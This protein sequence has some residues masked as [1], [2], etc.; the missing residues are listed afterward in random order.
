MKLCFN[1]AEKVSKGIDALKEEL[2]IEIVS[3]KSAEVVV[4]VGE[5]TENVVI[6][7]LKGTTAFIVYGGGKSRFFR[8]LATLV[9]WISD[10]VTE[11]R[12]EQHPLFLRNGAMGDMSG[13]MMNIPTLKQML[14]KMALMGLSTYMPYTEDTYEIE[15]RPYFGHMMGRY[16]KAELRE[17][18]EYANMLGI[19]LIPC[20]QVLGHM[21]SHLRWEAAAPYKDTESVL[22]ADADATY[23]LIDDM[24]RTV[25]ECF[26]TKRVHIGMDETK[27][28]GSGNFLEKN[29]FEPRQD[30]YFRHLERVKEIAAKYGLEPMMWSDMFFRL[31]GSKLDSYS[32]YDLR[33]EFSDEVKAKNPKGVTQVF[34]DYYCTSEE[35]YAVN[36]DKH[37]DLFGADPIFAGGVWLWSGQ[38][39]LYSLS[40]QNTIPALNACREKRLEEI[41]ATIWGGFECCH[42]MA[43]PGLAWYADY[44]YLGTHDIESVKQCFRYSCGV[45]Y[46]TMMLCELPAHPDGKKL[47]LTRGLLYNDPLLGLIDKHIDGIEMQEYYKVVTAK[48][49]AD[50]TDRGIFEKSYKTIRN[51]SS[52][53]QNKADFGVRLK[54]AYDLGDKDTLSQLASECDVIIEKLKA[55]YESHKAQW[56]AF[57]KSFGWEVHDIR[58]G[59]LITRFGT[60]KELIHQYL[61]GEIEKIEELEEERLRI[62]GR[63]GENAGPGFDQRFWWRRYS[64]YASVRTI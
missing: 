11:K 12:I 49:D 27:D 6:V 20:I 3:E 2:G 59:G 39:P 40:Y 33:V 51:L 55:L 16:S 36:I 46:D 50:E 47:S 14:R 9:G 25:S 35:F 61:N 30:I 53:L 29:G 64:V 54:K 7:D 60:V 21:A 45:S 24:L 58:Y 37:R 32:E 26:S 4:S 38:C 31:A 17:L 43:L 19:E 44:D 15:G 1:N 56:M 42:L 5:S 10:G 8:G 63:V 13:S 48:M 52:L 34:W 28:L 18:D 23:S 22:L 62:D 57:H 41:L